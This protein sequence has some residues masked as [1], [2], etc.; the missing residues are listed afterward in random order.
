MNFC[1]SSFS[2]LKSIILL[3]QTGYIFQTSRAQV[4]IH[5]HLVTYPTSGRRCGTDTHRVKEGKISG[6]LRSEA[7]PESLTL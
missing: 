1:E 3:K 4:P 6:H 2:I 7:P 5:K